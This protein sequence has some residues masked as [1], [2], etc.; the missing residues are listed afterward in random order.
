MNWKLNTE[1]PKS[2]VIQGLR[3]FFMIQFHGIGQEWRVNEMKEYMKPG[4]KYVKFL[5][6]YKHKTKMQE[7]KNDE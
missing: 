6:N 7:V 2:A 1:W 3:H 4:K 5:A